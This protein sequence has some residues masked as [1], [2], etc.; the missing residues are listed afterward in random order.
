M[1]ELLSHSELTLI[2]MKSCSHKN[3][4]PRWLFSEQVCITTNVSGRKKQQL[5]QKI[6]S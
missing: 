4:L 3:T 6:I 2:V 5:D 1:P